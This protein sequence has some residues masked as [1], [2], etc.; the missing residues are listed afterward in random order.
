MENGI[1]WLS[2]HWERTSSSGSFHQG[3][4]YI[5]IENLL[6]D[7][8][9]QAQSEKTVGLKTNLKS[10]KSTAAEKLPLFV[11]GKFNLKLLV[12]GWRCYANPHFFLIKPFEIITV[13]LLWVV[14]VFL[15]L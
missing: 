13:T 7:D 8:P 6:N 14:Q 12:I 10:L 9:E 15:G 1:Y 4:F 5:Q 11:L 2:L 3:N